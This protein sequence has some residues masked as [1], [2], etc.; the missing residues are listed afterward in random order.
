MGDIKLIRGKIKLS[1][2]QGDIEMARELK[3]LSRQIDLAYARIE[4]AQ[5]KERDGG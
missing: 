3:S 5:R 4:A 1:P 2:S